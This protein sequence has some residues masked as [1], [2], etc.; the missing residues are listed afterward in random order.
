MQVTA[1]QGRVRYEYQ[2]PGPPLP[3][4]GEPKP[5]QSRRTIRS[6]VTGAQ[7][8]ALVIGQTVM[9]RPWTPV[10]LWKMIVFDA[11]IVAGEG[12]EPPTFWL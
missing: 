10:T 8:R 12:F 3:L 7:K 5:D 6:Y 9:T 11:P 1:S 4:V 2:T